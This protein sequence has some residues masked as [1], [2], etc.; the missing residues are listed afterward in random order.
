VRAGAAYLLARRLPEAGVK[1]FVGM[2]HVS[3]A[4]MGA[5]A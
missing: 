5:M 1:F 2:H 4:F 3:G